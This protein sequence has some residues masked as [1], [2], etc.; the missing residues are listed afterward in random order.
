MEQIL[1]TPRELQAF[2]GLINFFALFVNLGRLHMRPRQHWL[3]CRWDHTLSSIDLP[4]L[5]TPDLLEAIK[6]WS[7]TEWILQGVPLLSPQPDIYLCTD[8]L[9]KGWGAS[10][11]GR[12]VKDVWRGSQRALHINYL[13]MLAV[14]LALQHSVSSEFDSRQSITLQA[15]VYRM[16]DQPSSFLADLRS[17]PHS[18]DRPI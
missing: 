16:A 17:T 2:L 10:L 14:K 11:S 15:S 1:V 8:I 3:A 7:D 18:V 9:M 12:D 5:V 13:E 6:V 4:L